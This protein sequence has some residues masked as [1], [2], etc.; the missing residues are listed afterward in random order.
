MFAESEIIHE[1]NFEGSQAW[2]ESIQE[3]ALRLNRLWD[4][5]DDLRPLWS[6]RLDCLHLH[7]SGKRALVPDYKTGFAANPPIAS[8]WQIK[9]EAVL[10]MTSPLSPAF[11]V[12]EVTAALIHPHHPDSLYETITFTRE[13]LELHAKTIRGLVAQIQ[14]PDQPRTPNGISCAFCRAK[15][16]CPEYQ[17]EKAKLAAAIIE[18]HETNG[19]DSLLRMTAAERGRRLKDLRDLEK[20]IERQ[21]EKFVGILR[22]DPESVKGW[23]LTRKWSRKISDQVEA[24]QMVAAKFGATARDHAVK[25]SLTALEEFLAESMNKREAHELINESLKPVIKFS[26]SKEY[27]EEKIT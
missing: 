20:H 10:A 3:E 8:N 25:L 16:V 22:G 5:D 9:G 18:E 11:G 1:Y 6:A 19:F 13:E 14:E 7:P 17:E 24:M 15:D 2:W 21:R 23:K 26:K 27:P 4:V 12:E